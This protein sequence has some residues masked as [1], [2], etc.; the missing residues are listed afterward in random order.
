M[1]IA[2]DIELSHS[3]SIGAEIYCR[4]QLVPC[5]PQYNFRIGK[6]KGNADHDH[7]TEGDLDEIVDCMTSFM[8]NGAYGHVFCSPRQCSIC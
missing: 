6:R 1:A 4:L 3:A 8:T 2:K 7:L 5:D